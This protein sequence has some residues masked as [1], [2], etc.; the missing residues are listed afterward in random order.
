MKIGDI[1]GLPDDTE[2]EI[3]SPYMNEPSSLP[4]EQWKLDGKTLNIVPDHEFTI[5]PIEWYGAHNWYERVSNG[6]LN[7]LYKISVEKSLTENEIRE[8]IDLVLKSFFGKVD[9]TRD[10]PERTTI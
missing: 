4:V 1:K 7:E 6:I 8:R 10:I 3:L 2:I 5:V 9:T